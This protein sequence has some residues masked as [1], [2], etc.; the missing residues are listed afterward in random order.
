MR[1][2]TAAGSESVGYRTMRALR[3]RL[4]CCVALIAILGC[5]DE[6]TIPTGGAP[7]QSVALSVDSDGLSRA[8][9]SFG[10]YVSDTEAATLLAHEGVVITGVFM[11][12]GG[13][14]G[15]FRPA[16]PAPPIAVIASARL[17]AIEDL[18]NGLVNIRPRLRGLQRQITL[19][20]LRESQAH[21]R[22][23]QSLLVLR[24]QLSQASHE[25]RTGVPL[26]HAV[27]VAGTEAEIGALQTV[28]GLAKVDRLV[29]RTVAASEREF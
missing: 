12:A 11:S 13:L 6:P 16:T 10:A 14:A 3:H 9:V 17:S 28:A 19:D 4:V 22:S 25:A 8:M 18:R 26:V 20:V 15:A 7:A 5:A 29:S 27:E 24:A 2:I 1:H 23:V 21:L